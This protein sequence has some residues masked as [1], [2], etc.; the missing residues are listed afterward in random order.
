MLNLSAVDLDEIAM[1]LQD[2][3]TYEYRWLLDPQ[4]GQIVVWTEDGG[5]DG[6]TP[7]ELDDVDL[8]PIG[9]LPSFAWY[10]DMAEFAEGISD[11]R[12]AGS[13]LRAIQGKG[14]FR[15]FKDRMHEDYLDLLPAWHAFQSSRAKRR[16]IEW[17][18]DNSLID[19]EAA[20]RAL[21]RYPDPSLP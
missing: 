18:V 14:A 10:R 5:I 13:L 19:Q 12:A 17:L 1:A 8:L 11:E 2:Q 15:R 7:V 4:S 9:P 20:E 3:T 16:A 6:R 21:A